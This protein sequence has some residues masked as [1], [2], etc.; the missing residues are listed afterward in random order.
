MRLVRD[1]EGSVEA[2]LLFIPTT[3]FF[4]LLLQLVVAGS[5]QTI[6]TMN[7]QSWLNKSA[8]YGLDGDVTEK[9]ERSS[10]PGGGEVL[11]LKQRTSVPRISSFPRTFNQEE[12]LKVATFALAVRE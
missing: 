2:G 11:T 4:L 6:E 10:L 8:L 3:A 12:G 5:M 1:E 7:I 9:I